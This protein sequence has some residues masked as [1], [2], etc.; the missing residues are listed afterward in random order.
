MFTTQFD[1]YVCI[2]DSIDCVVGPLRITAR[3]VHDDTSSPRD[4]DAPG[5]CFDT[6]DSEYGEENQATIAAWDNDEWF[7]CGV[8]LSVVLDD[9]DHELTDHGAA[10]WGIEC[11]MGDSG[12]AYL[13]D[14]ANELLQE[15]IDAAKEQIES[16]RE[17]IKDI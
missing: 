3:V 5:C 15:A 10:L 1:S 12:N 9:S 2:N 4:Y 16:I 7:Y 17:S 14:V 13:M 8:V 11:N 6:S